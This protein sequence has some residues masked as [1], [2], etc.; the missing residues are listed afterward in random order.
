[1]DSSTQASSRRQD[2]KLRTNN[3]ETRATDLRKIL[4]LAE[5]DES[6]RLIM[7][8]ALSVMGYVVAACPD[9]YVASATF[10][11][12]TIDVL[13]TDYEMPGKTGLEL[14]RELTELQPSLPV[15]VITGSLLSAAVLKEIHD[16]QWIYIRKPLDMSAVKST[17]ANLTRVHSPLA[18]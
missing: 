15:I 6:L 7:E 9:A 5:D 4:L 3:A 18:A 2:Q 1:V 13:L 8:Y 16:R 10:H 11:A 12:H 14:A 17:L